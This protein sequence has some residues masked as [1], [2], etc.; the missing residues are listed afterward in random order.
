MKKVSI[1]LA[2]GFEEVEALTPA[3]LLRRAGA[4]VTLVSI[5]AEKTVTGSHGI[6]ITAD[7]L[8][9]E[10]DY[11]DADLLVLPGGMP[12][13]LN[14]KACEPLLA[15][16][17]EHNAKGKKLAAICAAPTVLGHAGRPH[18]SHLPD[19]PGSH[20]W[21]HHHQPRRRHRDSLRPEPDRPALQPG[22]GGRDREEYC[23]RSI[24]RNDENQVPAQPPA[25]TVRPSKNFQYS[26]LHL[27]AHYHHGGDNHDTA[28]FRFHPEPDGSP[29]IQSSH[30][31]LQRRSSQRAGRPLK[32]GL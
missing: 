10:M 27:R 11:E 17:K 32:R 22:E 30:E 14:L 20:R 28:E 1:F 24:R 13:T 15:L 6:S 3:D 26:I 21:H 31:P 12:G 2:E 4:E 23:V 19:R 29:R 9:E 7:R 25:G 16:L 18:R 8:F 5:K